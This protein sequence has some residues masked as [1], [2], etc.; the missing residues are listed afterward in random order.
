M[1]RIVIVVSILVLATILPVTVALAQD[2]MFLCHIVVAAGGGVTLDC[3]PYVAPPDATATPMPTDTPIPPTATAI[4]VPPT[5]TAMPDMADMMWHAPGAH[6]DRPAHEHGDAPPQWVLDAGY[7]PMF[8]HAAGTP[9][10]NIANY[11]HT[12]FKGWMGRFGSVDWYGVFHLDTNPVGQAGRFHSYQL[13]A[14]DA[15]G[16]VSSFNGWLD[17]G[18]GNSATSQKIV[19]CATD[20]GTRPIIM[21]NQPGCAPRFENWYARAGGSGG[22]APDIGFN[23]S[24]TYYDIGTGDPNDVAQWRPINGAANNVQRRIEWAWYPF[25]SNLRG[26]FWATQFGDIVSGPSDP[27]CGTQQAHGTRVDTVLCLRQYIAPSLPEVS[28]TT[29]QLPNRNSQQRT[30]GGGGIVVLP[31]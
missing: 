19:V 17:F 12:A 29:T 3:T 30:F 1:R 23:I 10:E 21:V 11:K 15:T 13:W 2:G 16:A 9:G 6:G 31:N 14:R 24:P 18:T 20:S 8:T 25:R 7:T 22:W 26:E 4:P 28:F 27:R 5:A